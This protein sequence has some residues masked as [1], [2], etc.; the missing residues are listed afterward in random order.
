[1]FANSPDHLKAGGQVVAIHPDDAAALDLTSGI[2]VTVGNQ[3]GAFV[4]MLEV[5]EHARP[6]VATM[7]KGHWPKLSGGSSINAT[8][9]EA[10]ADMARGAIYHDNVVMITA[11]AAPTKNE[12]ISEATR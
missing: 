3:R 4:A 1:M 10:D 8:A 5:S 12:V 2:Q 7:T 9:L 11:V 6:G